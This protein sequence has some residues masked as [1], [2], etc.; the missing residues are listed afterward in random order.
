M[1]GN[2]LG[3]ATLVVLLPLDGEPYL[4]YVPFVPTT[5]ATAAQFIGI[6]LSEF[7]ALLPDGLID[8]VDPTMNQ[9]LFDITRAE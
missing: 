8:D 7:E 2:G 9:E 3:R 5:K 6:R 1:R 4:I